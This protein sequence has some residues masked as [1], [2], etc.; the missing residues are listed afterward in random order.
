[1][2]LL[3]KLINLL[4]QPLAWVAALLCLALLVQRRQPQ[5]ARQIQWL[6]LGLLLLVGWLPLPNGLLWQLEKQYPEMA[7]QADLRGYVGA[8]VLGGATESGYLAQAHQQPLLGG[9]AERMTA[10][11]AMRLR[12][13]H[14]RLVF[15]GGEGELV[16]SGPSEAVRAQGFFESMGLSANQVQYEAE[17]RNTFENALLTARLP[18]ID[19]TQ[20]WLLVTS[21]SH[22]PRSMATFAHAGWNVTAYPVDFRNAPHIPWNEYSLWQG[23]ERW[24]L[25]LHELLGL[26]AYRLTGRL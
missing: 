11:I 10:P 15:T 5:R 21:A 20:P 9:A 22:M 14:L 19:I 7:P 24:Q 23:A 26:L 3:S 2:Y 6:A 12:N 18:G 16:G 25:V 17:S 1:M 4:A 13:P 8:V